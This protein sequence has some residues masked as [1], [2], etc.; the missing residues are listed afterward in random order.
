[1]ALCHMFVLIT[2]FLVFVLKLVKISF[3]LSKPL[4]MGS[5]LVSARYRFN[6]GNTNLPFLLLESELFRFA[7][8]SIVKYFSCMYVNI[9]FLFQIIFS[10]LSCVLWYLVFYFFGTCKE[11]FK[12]CILVMFPI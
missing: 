9:W 8:D 6:H 1:M 11:V 2:E 12:L 10:W 3:I 5:T 4:P 7:F